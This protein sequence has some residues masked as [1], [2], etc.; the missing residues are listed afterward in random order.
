MSAE[1]TQD[2]GLSGILGLE[3]EGGLLHGPLHWLTEILEA[4][5]A[6]IDLAAILLLRIGAVRFIG[7]VNV[8]EVAK[9]GSERV[10]RTNRERIELGRYIWPGWNCSL[11][12]T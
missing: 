1:G 7:G 3:L 11:C 2:G 12:R 6:L 9:R 8:A 4:L 5:A 10:E